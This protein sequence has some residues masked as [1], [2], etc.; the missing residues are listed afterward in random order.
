MEVIRSATSSASRTQA[1]SHKELHAYWRLNKLP[2][3]LSSSCWF[4][5]GHLELFSPSKFSKT[6]NLV[7]EKKKVW[8]CRNLHN[9]SAK[10][11]SLYVQTSLPSSQR[12]QFVS[13]LVFCHSVL[14]LACASIKILSL[15]ECQMP[16]DILLPQRLHLKK[17]E[18]TSQSENF[19]PWGKYFLL[20]S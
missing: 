5:R 20:F 4:S 7:K 3:R 16:K 17:P 1:L 12:L 13:R 10:L 9:S 18:T 14:F 19:P 15:L 6:Y 11:S 8:F 2:C